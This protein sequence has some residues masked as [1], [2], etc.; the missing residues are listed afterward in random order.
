[1]PASVSRKVDVDGLCVPPFVSVLCYP[2]GSQSEAQRR[3][4]SLKEMGVEAL[5]FVGSIEVGG[6]K[7]LGKGHVGVVVECLWKGKRAA[8]KIR[9]TDADRESLE[10]EGEIL[11]ESNRSKIGPV[12]FAASRDFIVMEELVGNNLVDW[13]K[14]SKDLADGAFRSILTDICGLARLLD[15]AGVDHKELSDPR[16]H[17]IIQLDGRARVL[18]FETAATGGR[19]RNVNDLLQYLTLSRPYGPIVLSR[20]GAEREEVLAALRAYRRS[21]DDDSY[22]TILRSMKLAERP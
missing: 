14:G 21:P 20:L 10:R 12:L 1:M 2:S 5:V 8:L 6:L 3:I 17:V 13:L 18:D 4:I 7:V 9:R 19:R 16:R 22:R 15:V 11:K